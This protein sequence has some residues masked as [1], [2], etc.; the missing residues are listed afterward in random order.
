MDSDKMSKDLSDTSVM[1]GGINRE[2][3]ENE[4]LLLCQF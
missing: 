1:Y 3:E 2:R 4:V